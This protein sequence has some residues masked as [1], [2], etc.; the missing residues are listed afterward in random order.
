MLI[1]LRASRQGI[2]LRVG[3]R[4]C[5]V[6]SSLSTHSQKRQVKFHDMSLHCHN[7]VAKKRSIALNALLAVR[8]AVVQEDVDM[9]A[10][11]QLPTQIRTRSTFWQYLGRSVQNARLFGPLPLWAPEEFQASG[12]TYVALSSHPGLNQIGSHANSVHLKSIVESS[13]SLH[14]TRP[15]AVRVVEQRERRLDL[16]DTEEEHTEATLRKGVEATG[17]E[18]N[19]DTD[20]DAH[21]DE[22]DDGCTTEIFAGKMRGIQYAVSE[23]RQ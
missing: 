19:H 14:K 13:A 21:D 1:D 6:Q 23:D 2:L 9:V 10:C 17:C 22:L 3:L 4:G 20:N 18:E 15:I 12:L 5:S 16:H 7:V 11:C 8:T